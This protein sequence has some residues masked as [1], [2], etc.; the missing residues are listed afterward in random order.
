MGISETVG[1]TAPRR[2]TDS[3]REL[4]FVERVIVGIDSTIAL[5]RIRADLR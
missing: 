5:L 3:R 1:Q 4:F 2:T